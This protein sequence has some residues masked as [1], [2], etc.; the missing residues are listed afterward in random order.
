[1]KNAR[2]TSCVTDTTKH[3]IKVNVPYFRGTFIT[4]FYVVKEKNNT[5]SLS[6]LIRT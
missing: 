1:M 4:F 2:R 6:L 5:F 3:K